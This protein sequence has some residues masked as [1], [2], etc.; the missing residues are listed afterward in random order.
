MFVPQ[1]TA[2]L[3]ALL[4]SSAG[5][6]HWRLQDGVITA[7]NGNMVFS[8]SEPCSSCAGE[9]QE[10]DGLGEVS[11]VYDREIAVLARRY[12]TRR[13]C[14]FTFVDFLVEGWV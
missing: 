6:T 4:A 8:S 11:V 3:T 2:L 5:V 7:V 13:S 14:K 10:G 12:S 9:S 1:A